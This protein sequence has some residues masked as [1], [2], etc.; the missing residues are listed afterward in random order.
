[1]IQP[2]IEKP[3]STAA[4]EID[5]SPSATAKAKKKYRTQ[6]SEGFGWPEKKKFFEKTLRGIDAAQRVES[7]Y[8]GFRVV[9]FVLGGRSGVENLVI[10]TYIPSG[11]SG[12]SENK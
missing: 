6:I 10:S 11:R 9:L 5:A 8:T 12:K 2:S 7:I 4:S 1:M 3:R